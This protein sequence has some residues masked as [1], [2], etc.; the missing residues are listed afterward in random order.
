MPI[1]QC[2]PQETTAITDLYLTFHIRQYIDS[3]LV[4]FND[5]FDQNNLL[6]IQSDSRLKTIDHFTRCLSI[7]SK[8]FA[9]YF[10]VFFKILFFGT[11]R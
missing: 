2:V 11:L 9:I 10:L 8:I 5:N 6:F 4:S 3:F 1:V 7:F